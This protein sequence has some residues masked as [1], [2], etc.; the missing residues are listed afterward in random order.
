VPHLEHTSAVRAIRFGVFE[1]DLDGRELRKA[2]RKLHLRDQ[3]LRILALLASRPGEVISREELRQTLWPADVF[4]DFEHSINAAINKLRETLGDSA[5]SPRFIETVPRRGYRFVAPVEPLPHTPPPAA[6]K[7]VAF[8]NPGIVWILSLA[9]PLTAG[10][11]WVFWP[12]GS[13]SPP[14]VEEI[15]LTSYR[16][17]ERY[18]SFSPDASQVAFSWNGP[19]GDNSDI[20]VKVIGSEEPLRLTDSPDDE[21]QPAWSPDGRQIAFLRKKGPAAVDLLLVPALG[22]PARP[23]TTLRIESFAAPGYIPWRVHAWLPDG[24]GFIVADAAEDGQSRALYRLLLTTGERR[25]IT[26]PEGTQIDADPAF[27]PDRRQ[28]AFSRYFSA[29][30]SDQFTLAMTR[31]YLP[32]GEPQRRY[33]AAGQKSTHPVWSQDGAWLFFLSGPQHGKRLFKIRADGSGPPVPITLTTRTPDDLTIAP[34]KPMAAYTKHLFDVNIWRTRMHS[35]RR[36]RDTAPLLASSYLDHLPA[37]SPDGTRISFV[38]NRSGFSDLWVTRR[39]GSGP[40]RLTQ[41]E[42]GVVGDH[43][44]SPDG[45]SIVFC[46]SLGPHRGLYTIDAEGRGAPE[47]LSDETADDCDPSFSRDGKWIYFGSDRSGQREVWRMP[48]SG[49][50]PEQLT[51]RGGMT[52][53]E[54]RD[55]RS[56][57]YTKAPTDTGVWRMPVA[58]G[59]ETQV[60][61]ALVHSGA[62]ALSD[63][64]IYFAPAADS[65]GRSSLNFLDFATGAVTPIHPIEKPVMWGLAVSPKAD[66]VLFSCADDFGSD[67]MLVR[68]LQ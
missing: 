56:L 46:T 58:G 2:G 59:Q 11:L 52:P 54:S 63:A 32:L 50:T 13:D 42:A 25:P 66:E 51:R 17:A 26:T 67:L 5:S 9:L 64:G 53:V 16:G 1:L 15:P 37:Y 22:G 47:R 57:Y 29:V 65:R 31:D 55:G 33:H 34:R 39:D 6:R 41:F 14:P 8:R 23:V 24:S 60:I 43:N 18:P 21:L 28:L 48:A 62:F 68:N 3:P 10:L 12:A 4:V 30:N 27:S 35:A 19:E 38:S 20:Y 36:A 40:T 45:R 44:W 61:P 7:P 49:G